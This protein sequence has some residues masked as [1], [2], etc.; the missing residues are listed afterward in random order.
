MKKLGQLP[1][2]VPR[3]LE[4]QQSYAVKP[5]VQQTNEDILQE[6]A[7]SKYFGL[8]DAKSGYWHVPI[9]RQINLMTTYSTPSGK[10]KWLRLPFGLKVAQDVLQGRLDRVLRSICNTHN[11]AN[12]VLSHGKAEF[13]HDTIVIKLL[14]TVRLNS[15]TFNALMIVFKSQDSK[16]FG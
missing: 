1:G 11:I 9:D 16:F 6:L 10:F 2:Y 12:N 8:L 13:L 14:E 5:L 7:N 3:S 15:I 4:F